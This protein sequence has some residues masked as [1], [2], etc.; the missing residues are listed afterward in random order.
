[1]MTENN[2]ETA[3]KFL[4]TNE[5]RRFV[6]F[7]T[8]CSR[9]QYIGICYGTPGVGKT[10]SARNLSKQDLR[11][12]VASSNYTA[13]IPP[14]IGK[15]LA[16]CS[17]LYYTVQVG[18][19][20]KRIAEEL[21]NKIGQKILNKYSA[22]ND[23]YKLVIIDEADRLKT[24]TLEQVRA[25]YDYRNIGMVLIGMPGMEK[26]L[27]RYPQFYSRVGFAHEFQRIS[28]KDIH[29]V[30]EHYWQK[31]GVSFEQDKEAYTK[32]M[33]NILLITNGNFRLMTRLFSQIKRIMQINNLQ[34]ITEDVIAAARDCLVIGNT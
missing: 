4:I 21:N 28:K 30:L 32:I 12:Q 17:I 15:E 3:S 24:N 10:L 7:C 31:V 9:E 33:N 34:I 8:A 1:M 23:R 6:E 16:N 13:P 20:P 5:Y 19:T 27:A 25:I 29:F 2:T 22:P 26:R 14:K 18:N 11:D